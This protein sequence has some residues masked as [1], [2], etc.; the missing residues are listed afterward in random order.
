M[1]KLEKSSDYKRELP[2]SILLVF[3]SRSRHFF[4]ALFAITHFLFAQRSV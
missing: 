1:A 3:D 2:G 4:L